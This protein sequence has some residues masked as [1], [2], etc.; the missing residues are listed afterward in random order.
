MSLATKMLHRVQTPVTVRAKSAAPLRSAVVAG[1]SAVKQLLQQVGPAACRHQ[2]G[3]KDEYGCVLV[4]GCVLCCI[5]RLFVL[6]AVC[7]R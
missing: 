6:C 1:L 7:F 2:A 3:L 4:C 5:C